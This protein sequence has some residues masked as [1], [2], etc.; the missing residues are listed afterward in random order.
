MNDRISDGMLRRILD[1]GCDTRPKCNVGTETPVN[2]DAWG[3]H[4]YPLAMVYAPIQ[5]FDDLYDEETALMTGTIFKKLD[6]PFMGK[7]VT[8]GGGCRG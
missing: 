4:G 3:L 2:K 8:K 7:T 5:D 6:L 1:D